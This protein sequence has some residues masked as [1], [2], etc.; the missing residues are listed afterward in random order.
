MLDIIKMHLKG[1]VFAVVV[2]LI[3]LTVSLVTGRGEHG[4]EPSGAIKG[5]FHVAHN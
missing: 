3:W 4:S 1:I 5:G 2:G